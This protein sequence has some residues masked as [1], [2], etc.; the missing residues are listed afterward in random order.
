MKSGI[1]ATLIAASGLYNLAFAVFHLL[2]W[3]LFAWP[4]SLANSGE[5]N[6]AITQTLNVVL[7]YCF[8]A[9]GGALLW[10]STRESPSISALLA[11]GGGF[12]LLRSVLQSMLFTI[13]HKVATGI[14]I[15][16]VMGAALHLIAAVPA[17]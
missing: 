3:R 1:E 16:F 4:S 17:L 5:L 12:W 6:C 10:L 15:V 7:I 8:V 9:Y 13:R 14:T 11:A 2:F